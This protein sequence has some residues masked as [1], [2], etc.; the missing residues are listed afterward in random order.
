MT[1]VA[2]TQKADQ[3]EII[4]FG[5]LKYH[6]CFSKS[7]RFSS[8]RCSINMQPMLCDLTPSSIIIIISW[9]SRFVSTI[10]IQK[11]NAFAYLFMR[12]IEILKNMNATPARDA[13]SSMTITWLYLPDPRLNSFN[14]Q[15]LL[16]D[17]IIEYSFF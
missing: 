10:Y 12:K 14:W 4:Q 5:E 17:I 16:N 6:L 8:F 2:N 7:N 1:I 13:E 15:I 11:C 9:M 3:L